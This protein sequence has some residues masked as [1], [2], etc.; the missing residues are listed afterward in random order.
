MSFVLCFSAESVWTKVGE[1]IVTISQAAAT[2]W[3]ELL[4]TAFGFCSV[5]NKSQL[6]ERR[7]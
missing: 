4:A 6:T 2:A 1:S 3:W 7:N 5:K